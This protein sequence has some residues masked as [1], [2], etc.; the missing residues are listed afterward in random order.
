MKKSQLEAAIRSARK[1]LAAVIRQYKYEPVHPDVA[2]FIANRDAMLHII[3][4]LDLRFVDE[5]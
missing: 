5:A 3:N 1:E 2:V 4:I